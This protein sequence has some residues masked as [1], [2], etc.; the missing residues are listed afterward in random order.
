MLPALLAGVL[1]FAVGSMLALIAILASPI[2]KPAIVIELDSPRSGYSQ[3]FYA[4]EPGD[5]S[6]RNSIRQRVDIGEN[7]LHFPVSGLR[8]T[9]GTH[10][11]WDPLETSASMVVRSFTV[12][13]GL[14]EFAPAEGFMRP[15]VDV[16]EI[17]STPEGLVV[18]TQ[19]H[20]GQVLMDLDL[21]GFAQRNLTIALLISGVV[22]LALGVATLVVVWRGVV[23][24]DGRVTAS[25]AM[26][27]LVL[28]GA[29]LLSWVFVLR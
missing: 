17:R 23:Q 21:S 10:Q 6:E 1:A 14:T 7:W 15:S 4:N 29:M 25:A 11:R 8:E 2:G 12:R 5:F 26:A 9:T 16:A 24:L 22:G 3:M 20:D 28:L 27:L 18:E 19:S 13:S